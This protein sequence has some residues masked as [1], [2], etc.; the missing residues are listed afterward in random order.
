MISLNSIASNLGTKNCK[1]LALIHAF[2]G[3]N[4]TS[5]IKSKGNRYCCNLIHKVPSLIEEFANVV[6]TP[7]QTSP[8]MKGVASSFV[9][10]LYSN[11][12]DYGKDVNLVLPKVF[13]QTTRDV[14]RIPSTSDASQKRRLSSEHIWTTAH[15]SMMP[16]GNPT[17]HGWKEEYG[18]LLPIW[19]SLPLARDV[20]HLDVKCSCKGTCSICKCTSVKL[21]CT[22]LCKCTCEK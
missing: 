16:V 6:D 5:L 15:M 2:T 22:R 3:S 14:E 13:S 7:F 10:R 11:D 21:S 9:C 8:R 1:V 18:K 20:L 4:S 19:T 12:S 17:D